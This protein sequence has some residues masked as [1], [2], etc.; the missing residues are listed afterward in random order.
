MFCSVYYPVEISNVLRAII[1]DNSNNRYAIIALPCFAYAIKLAI[2]KATKLKRKVNIVASLVCGQLQNRFYSE[3][4]SLQSGIRVD[5]L[6]HI[7]FRRKFKGK[8]AS[9]FAQ[10]PISLDG[11]EGVPQFN[12]ELPMFLWQ[13]KY[14][15]QNACDFCDDVFGETA[16]VVFMDAWL[17]EYKND[18]QGTSLIVIRKP[19]V[20]DI[21]K[22]GINSG[23]YLHPI[24]IEKYC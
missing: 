13:Y 10:V 6:S 14:F 4:L 11:P 12:H 22:N 16:D 8:L 24:G 18:Y 23:G 2:N 1:N 19:E 7:V 9:N 20:L 21:F 5:R 17:P 3:F 15:T